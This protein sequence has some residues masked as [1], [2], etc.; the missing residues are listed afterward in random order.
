MKKDKKEKKKT[1]LKKLSEVFKKQ[2][3][4]KNSD[5]CKDVLKDFKEASE[6]GEYS[7]TLQ[8]KTNQAHYI[9]S[10]GLT[11]V[12]QEGRIGFYEVSWKK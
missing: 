3:D 8:L 5:D 1:Q 11:I 6:T 2:A 7:R 9:E 10:L 12:E 4:K